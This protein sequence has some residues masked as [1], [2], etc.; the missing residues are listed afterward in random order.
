M[1]IHAIS[2]AAWDRVGAVSI[3][4]L[5]IPLTVAA[6]QRRVMGYESWQPSTNKATHE[7]LSQSPWHLVKGYGG[8][9]PKSTRSML[10]K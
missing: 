9:P 2:F 8:V 10:G 5:E 3:K 6:R 1:I 4:T 7:S